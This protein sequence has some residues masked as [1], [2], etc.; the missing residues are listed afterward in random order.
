M[1]VDEDAI[2]AFGNRKAWRSVASAFAVSGDG[3]AASPAAAG[4][5]GGAKGASDGFNVHFFYASLGVCEGWE[6][7]EIGQ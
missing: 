7:S 4:P 6:V 1:T 3:T 5:L 2:T